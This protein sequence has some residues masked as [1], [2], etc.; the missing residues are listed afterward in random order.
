MLYAKRCADR[1][2]ER[3]EQPQTCLVTHAVTGLSLS[4]QC[5]ALEVQEPIEATVD[6]LLKTAMQQQAQ[7]ARVCCLTKDSLHGMSRLLL[8]HLIA[9]QSGQSAKLQEHG[10]STGS[11]SEA[12]LFG[13]DSLYC[14]HHS[15][16]WL[17]VQRQ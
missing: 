2:P 12:I 17:S 7:Q 8:I 3:R 1:R 10:A 9:C 5:C 14:H 11:T 4:L 6:F 15:R 16:L 13:Q